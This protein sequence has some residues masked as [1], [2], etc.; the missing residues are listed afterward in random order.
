M[1]KMNIG[2]VIFDCDGTLINSEK[3]CCQAL[4]R[5]F[6]RLGVNFTLTQCIDHFQGGKLAD[7]L[8]DMRQVA[9]VQTSLDL[10]EPMYRREVSSLFQRSLQP[11]PGAHNVIHYLNQQ[12]I[13]YAVATN[14]P[15]ERSVFSLGLTGLLPFFRGKIFSGFDINS[16]KPEPDLIVY[17]AMNMGFSLEECI[18]IDDTP[19]GVEAGLN[20][21]LQTFQ[22]FNGASANQVNDKRVIRLSDLCELKQYISGVGLLANG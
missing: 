2:C 3:L 6:S 19:K 17:S 4:V 21:G 11:M 14:A 5:I 16:W 20:A 7:I 22:L 1:T 8:S 13:E 15:T 18:Y 9:G 10:L 12:G